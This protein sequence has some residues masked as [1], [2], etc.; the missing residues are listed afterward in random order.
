MTPDKK[1]LTANQN[2]LYHE[3]KIMIAVQSYVIAGKFM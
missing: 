1:Q 3:G 2:M